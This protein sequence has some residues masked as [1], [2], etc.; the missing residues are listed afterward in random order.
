[1][2]LR[3]LKEVFPQMINVTEAYDSRFSSVQWQEIDGSQIAHVELDGEK[4]ELL[5]EPATFK[6]DGKEL[7]WLNIAFARDIDGKFSTELI[8]ST[9][10]AS[11]VIGTVSNAL[12]DKIKE[13]DSKFDIKAIGLAVRSGEEKRLATYKRF[14]TSKSALENGDPEEAV[15]VLDLALNLPADHDTKKLLEKAKEEADIGSPE[16]AETLLDLISLPAKGKK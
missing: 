7:T 13:L 2:Q 10:N 12:K 8:G 9:S 4:F 1:M 14:I 16:R 5:V 3:D 11:A 6:V 15:S